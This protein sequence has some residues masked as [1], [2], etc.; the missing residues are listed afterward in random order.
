MGPQTKEARRRLGYVNGLSFQ[1]ISLPCHVIQYPPK[2]PGTC[3]RKG[4]GGEAYAFNEMLDHVALLREFYT[5]YADP[6]Q[7]AA[8]LED[9]EG[10]STHPER[11]ATE[12]SATERSERLQ[13]GEALPWN[14]TGPS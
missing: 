7:G 12:R 1:A 5:P 14:S 6:S 8:R 4:L 9:C 3:E 11:S 2:F 10:L 13:P